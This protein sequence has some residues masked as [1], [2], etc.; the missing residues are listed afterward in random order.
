MGKD[1]TQVQP[2]TSN[3]KY[4]MPSI[5][6][7]SGQASSTQE[8][9]HDSDAMPEAEVGGSGIISVS[10]TSRLSASLGVQE[11]EF[12]NMQK[13]DPAGTLKLLLSK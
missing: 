8:S 12:T 11:E 5:S 13:S 7:H 1:G 6:T 9:H 4:P 3:I 2:N 10:S